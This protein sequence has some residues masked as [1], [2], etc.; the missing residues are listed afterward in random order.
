MDPSSWMVVLGKHFGLPVIAELSYIDSRQ[1][2]YAS[3][4][5]L[6]LPDQFQPHLV[7]VHLIL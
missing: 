2:D 1:D 3:A 5:L 4:E 6:I 7:P